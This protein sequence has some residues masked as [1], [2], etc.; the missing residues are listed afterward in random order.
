MTE[1]MPVPATFREGLRKLDLVTRRG[2]R[3]GQ[4]GEQTSA[5]KGQGVEFADHRPYTP[6]DDPRFLDWAAY[7]RQGRPVIKEFLE[8]TDLALTVVVDASASMGLPDGP[9][10][11][12]VGAT[13]ATLLC[14]VALLRHNR[15]GLLVVAENGVRYLPP[16]RG[17]GQMA[18]ICEALQSVTPSGRTRLAAPLAAHFSAVRPDGL[19]YVVSDLYEPSGPDRIIDCLVHFG[20]DGGVILMT[21]ADEM[22]RLPIGPAQLADSET[23]EMLRLVISPERRAEMSAA[24]GRWRS[25]IAGYSRDRGIILVEAEV[26]RPVEAT[27]QDWAQRGWVVR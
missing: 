19:V 12:R 24:L 10:R 5:R 14:S 20:L 7:A 11:Y 9:S 21:D 26:H 13:I 4:R 22:N 3:T 23:P 17:D 18:L 27:I 8:E 2:S 25:E 15:A 6:G 16:L 1:L